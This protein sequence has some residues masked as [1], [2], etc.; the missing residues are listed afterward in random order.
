M[1]LSHQVSGI[2]ANSIFGPSSADA[3]GSTGGLRRSLLP[4]QLKRLVVPSLTFPTPFQL[5]AFPQLLTSLDCSL[6]SSVLGLSLDLLTSLLH[7]TLTSLTLVNVRA[8]L[9]P[10]FWEQKLVAMK[11]SLTW[12]DLSCCPSVND[13][14]INTAIRPL[15][16]LRS[17]RLAS[18]PVSGAGLRSLVATSPGEQGTRCLRHLD[19]SG[20]L[21]VIESDLIP[22]A[23]HLSQL[24]VSGWI[25]GRGKERLPTTPTTSMWRLVCMLIDSSGG[26]VVVLCLFVACTRPWYWL[27]WMASRLVSY[28]L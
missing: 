28:R 8:A 26:S 5:P 22:L 9:P 11:A 23:H 24:Q 19:C 13:L 17:L 15:H 14:V 25:K 21:Y 20:A 4:P 12:L 2:S 1:C 16:H 27:G 10:S 7:P 6:P 18:C 3:S